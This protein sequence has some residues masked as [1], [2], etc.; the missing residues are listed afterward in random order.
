MKKVAILGGTF[1]P[2]HVEHINLAIKAIEELNLDK[3]LI[4][5]TFIPPH[6]TALPTSAEHR[7]NMLKLA[8]SGIDKVEI[9]D[10]EIKAKGK[11]YSYLTAEHFKKEL[12]CELFILVGAD[13]LQDFP[14]WRYPERILNA[15]TLV[16]FKRADYF[17]KEE[18]EKQKFKKR[19]NKDLIMLSYFGKEVSSTRI[20]VYNSLGLDFGDD[21]P[22]QVKEYILENGLY[23]GDTYTDFIKA[24]L[25]EKRIIHT[26]EVVICAMQKCKELS[27]DSNK[28]RI[29]TLLHD[30]AK[31]SD[32]TKFQ[33]FTL[34]D[35]VPEPVIH[36]FLGAHIAQNIL[37]IQDEEIIDAIKY[38]TSGK[39]NMTTLGK[40]VFVAD[41]VEKNRNYEGVEILR[42][43]Y[44]KD[45]ERCFLECLKEE[46]I[47]LKN[48]KQ[49][50][51]DETLNAYD[52]YI[53]DKL[54]K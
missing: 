35:G 45:F 41:M 7:L 31:Y 21:T 16:A 1:D 6:K 17:I 50:I 26:A 12:D 30:C 3:L 28:V 23:S 18:L 25:P 40:L 54:E 5:P 10:Y 53:K 22:N 36:A 47:H 13:M 44:E 27:L 43:L 52:Y 51:Y 33:D 49:Y 24:M 48:K 38:H 39:A 2:V 4:V 37:G 34:P 20:R 15:C 14:T 8:F 29:A 9:S 19:Y 32:Y 11:S 42:D 46:V